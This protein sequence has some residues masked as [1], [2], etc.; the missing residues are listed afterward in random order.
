MSEQA[1]RTTA[2]S[3]RERRERFDTRR[4]KRL[5]MDEVRARSAGMAAALDEFDA[6]LAPIADAFT[7]RVAREFGVLII[8]QFSLDKEV[9]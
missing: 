1:V 6:E 9:F 4:W 2:R 8:W 5:G 3:D 7:R